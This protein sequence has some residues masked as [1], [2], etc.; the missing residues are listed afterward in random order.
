MTMGM[1]VKRLSQRRPRQL[2]LGES[3]GLGGQTTARKSGAREVVLKF[4]MPPSVN[5]QFIKTRKRQNM[6]SGM[7]LA[8]VAK[9]F[10]NHVKARV[11]QHPAIALGQFPTQDPEVAYRLE[12]ALCFKKLENEGWFQQFK[13][14]KNAGQRKAQTRYVRVDTDNRVKFLKDCLCK[15][16]GIPDDC[17]IFEDQVWK[18]KVEGEAY[19]MVRL[20]VVDEEDYINVQFGGHGFPRPVQHE[21]AGG[22]SQAL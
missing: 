10:K 6:K 11:A 13:R 12:I 2:E 1:R 5:E 16:M 21:R 19:V 15:S 22:D 17:Q 9:K 7:A 3:A 14:G 18:V 4:D 8:D 20:T